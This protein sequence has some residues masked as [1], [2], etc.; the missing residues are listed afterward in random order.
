MVLLGRAPVLA[1]ELP[2]GIGIF[3]R[4]GEPEAEL[5]NEIAL[6]LA[7][8]RD[9]EEDETYFTLGAEYERRFTA[10]FGLVAEL[11]Y[12]F[13]AERWIVAAPVVFRPARGLKLFAGPGFERADDEEDD[14]REGGEHENGNGGA[15]HFLFRIGAGY[16]VEFAEH[17][18]VGPT[19]SVDVI[20]ERGTWVHA[21]VFGVTVG[22]G[23]C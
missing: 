10:R 14:E 6:I 22:V 19:F 3:Q 4:Q 1:Q 23:F 9:T 21:L 17:Y 5:R 11:E 20:R 15:T 7:G 12:L 13:A 18:S 8:T 16:G 2:R